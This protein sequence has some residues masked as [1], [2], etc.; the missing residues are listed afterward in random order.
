METHILVT[1]ATGNVGLPAV[2]ELVS[3]G[4]KVRA[5]TRDPTRAGKL[6]LS[7]VEVIAGDLGRPVSVNNAIRDISH[8]LLIS[9]VDNR[10]GRDAGGGGGCGPTSWREA[11]REAL[12][13]GRCGRLLRSPC[14]GGTGKS[15]NSS[16]ARVW[17]GPICGPPSSCK[18]LSVLVRLFAVKAHFSPV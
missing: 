10:H 8:V 11:C 1:G 14:S 13:A 5:L 15:K 3:R 2:R 18:T 7:G 16:S 17:P 9:P 6:R 4:L 12:G